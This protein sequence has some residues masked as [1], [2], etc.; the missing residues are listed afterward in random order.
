[1]KHVL[2]SIAFLSLSL[3]ALRGQVV[4]NR[5]YPIKMSSN[6]PH[7]LLRQSADRILF[8]GMNA[9]MEM[10]PYGTVI[11]TGLGDDP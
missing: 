11:S 7:I 2:F 10:D 4:W 6:M 3:S 8:Y 1:M 5:E 9:L